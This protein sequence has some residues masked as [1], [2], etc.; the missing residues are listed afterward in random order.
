MTDA[1]ARLES[2]LVEIWDEHPAAG[3][4]DREASLVSLGVDSVTLVTLLNR[5]ESE[6]GFRWD[7]DNPPGAHSSLRSIASCLPGEGSR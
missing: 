2:I 5:A 1:V 4:V 6:L 3:P 7:M